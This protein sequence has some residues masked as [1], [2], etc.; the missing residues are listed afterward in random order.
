[1]I[2]RALL[3]LVALC[4]LTSPLHSQDQAKLI[5]DQVLLEANDTLTAEGAVEVLYKGTRL[6]AERI[7]YFSKT[8]R[9]EITGPIRLTDESN[10]VIVA[11]AADLSSDLTEGVLTS[12][13]MVLDQQLQIASNRLTRASGRFTV[14]DRVVASSCEVCPSNPTPLWEIRARRVVH[15]QEER[16]LYFDHAQFRVAGLPIFY[17]PRL[18]MPDPTLERSTGFLLPTIRTTSGL[19]AGVKLPY[20]IAIGD[21]R[22][23]TLTPYVSAKQTRTLEFRYRQA[24]RTGKMEFSGALSRDDLIPGKTRGY[25]FGN[26]KFDLPRDFGLN[27]KLQ[28]VTDDAYLLD[29][30]VS[31]R[32]RLQSGVELTRTR[33]NEHI[34][35]RIFRYWSIRARDDN[36]VLPTLVGD[37]TF[38]RRFRPAY[39]GGEGKFSFQTHSHRR[40][41]T[42]TTDANGD[43]ITD[44]RDIARTTLAAD[45]SRNWTLS[46]GMVLSGGFMA[47]ADFYS[48]GQDATYPGTVTRFAPSAMVELR[49][50]WVKTETAGG[51]TQV[52]E[53]V[54][55]LV[56]SRNDIE[57]VPNEDSQ[58]SSFDEG[59]LFGYS[60]FPGVD[61]RELGTR[62][63]LGV[64]W[65]RRDPAGWSL[66]VTAGRV[67]RAEDLGQFS[68]GSGLDGTSS[69]WL[70]ATH[71]DTAFGLTMMNRALFDDAFS[72]SRN[73][74]RLGYNAQKYDISAGYL[75]LM[76][77]PAEGR[78][79]ASSEFTFDAGWTFARNWRGKVSGRYDFQADRAAKAAVGLQYRNECVA[80]DLSLSRRFTS[81]TSVSANT[82]FSMSV[83]LAGFGAGTDGRKYRR[84]CAR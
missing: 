63:N 32:D 72:F 64:S 52:I 23:L 12:A 49:W 79:K 61:E 26:A 69:D 21:S 29:Y 47:A 13:R 53:P 41:S 56:W 68:I 27:L 57:D 62:L 71:L 4:L 67:F 9:L 6:T 22:D 1:M 33:R 28:T 77:D 81:S 42:V 14:L 78:N 83:E 58:I 38:E 48:I 39:L 37:L 36:S 50:P 34:D 5:A 73:E 46:N 16:Q 60:R 76:A 18:R 66:G 55:Q 31:S 15:D 24:F 43:G 17:A 74:L 20:F 40:S 70:L 80:V 19:G 44:G 35:A 82:D 65:T 25:L 3:A 51:A 8:D 2:R 30:D 54:A 75:W 7:I 45:W 59:N 11:D 84:S 10:T